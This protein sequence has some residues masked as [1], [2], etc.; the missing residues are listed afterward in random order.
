M[1]TMLSQVMEFK[2]NCGIAAVL[3]QLHNTVLDNIGYNQ[4]E[5]SIH[6]FP[7]NNYLVQFQ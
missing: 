1:T 5:L 4:R 7:T 6:N 2:K 3:K